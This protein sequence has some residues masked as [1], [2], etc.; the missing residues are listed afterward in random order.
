MDVLV[1]FIDQ[2][3]YRDALAIWVSIG[4]LFMSK[5]SILG[6]K[7]L[8][9]L[10]VIWYHLLLDL[11][12]STFVKLIDFHEIPVKVLKYV[13]MILKKFRSCWKVL[14]LQLLTV[15]QRSWIQNL[16]SQALISSHFHN[17]A[18]GY[19]NLRYWLNNAVVYIFQRIQL[20]SM[21]LCKLQN[22]F[23]SFW[24]LICLGRGRLFY[25]FYWPFFIFQ[26]IELFGV[27]GG[28]S[29]GCGL[30]TTPTASSGR[31]WRSF[32]TG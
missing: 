26:R 10:W 22:V 20:E 11:K 16:V 6:F 1:V 27:G 2:G 3:L 15:C 4:S 5:V 18:Q 31:P 14:K 30:S 8:Q 7:Q 25:L 23:K 12:G 13:K 21:Y 29:E 17:W 32:S 19:W 28:L 24:E 9:M